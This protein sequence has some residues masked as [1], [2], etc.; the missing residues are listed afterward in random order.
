MG[1]GDTP[2]SL[3]LK[4]GGLVAFRFLAGDSEG[5]FEV[6]WPSYEEYGE[7]EDEDEDAGERMVGG[8]GSGEEEED[9]L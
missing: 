2:E 3:G 8:G 6:Q 5:D 1:L 4:E 7:G 9:E